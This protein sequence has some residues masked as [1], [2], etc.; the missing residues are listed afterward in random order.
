[1][2]ILL[3]TSTFLWWTLGSRKI[4]ENAFKAI[5]DPSNR[6][7]LSSAS[8]W[9]IAIKYASGRLDLPRPAETFVPM[10][11]EAHAI[12]P[13]PIGDAEAFQAGKLQLIH[14]DPFDRMLI[15]QS[16]VHSLSIATSDPKIQAYPC[17][18]FWER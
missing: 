4:P 13:L 18:W 8:A 3:D 5:Q 6:V 12:E 11:R 16:I 15:A 7:L 17:R 9:E 10:M 2:D 14:R 1:M